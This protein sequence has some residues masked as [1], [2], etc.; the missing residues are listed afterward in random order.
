MD[1]CGQ[2]QPSVIQQERAGF[3]TLPPGVG[4]E[5]EESFFA[6]EE[7]QERSKPL[8]T[9]L[10]DHTLAQLE[11]RLSGLARLVTALSA[12]NSALRTMVAERDEYIELVEQ[13][14]ALLTRQVERFETA[15][16]QV[17]DGLSDILD[18]FAGG[19]MVLQDEELFDFAD[20]RLLEETIGTA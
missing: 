17:I 18:R 19:E 6:M 13:E 7:L 15:Q 5:A 2:Q 14:N 12:K 3:S 8:P 4:E 10:V 11:A 20:A 16:S 9:G 1:L